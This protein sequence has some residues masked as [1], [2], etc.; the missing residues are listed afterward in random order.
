LEHFY[1]YNAFEN[2]EFQF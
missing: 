1:C 2:V